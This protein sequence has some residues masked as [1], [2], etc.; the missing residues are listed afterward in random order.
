[1]KLIPGI[2]FWI[3]CL[4]LL[5]GRAK[6]QDGLSYRTITVGKRIDYTGGI[7]L[8]PFEYV[9]PYSKIMVRIPSAVEIHTNPLKVWADHTPMFENPTEVAG[10]PLDKDGNFSN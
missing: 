5:P 9:L 10:Y 1:M 7:G 4:L 2:C 8:P 3:V 6:S